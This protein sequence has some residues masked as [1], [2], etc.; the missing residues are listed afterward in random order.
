MEIRRAI[1]ELSPHDRS[2]LTALLW[3]DEETP[4]HLHEKLAQAEAG[5]FLPGD[6][7]DVNRIF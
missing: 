2:E 7:A 3:P 5:R 1:D 4:P 6:R